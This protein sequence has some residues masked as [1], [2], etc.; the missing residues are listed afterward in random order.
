M[1]SRPVTLP[2][3]AGVRARRQAGGGV[4]EDAAIG[5][6]QSRV[7]PTKQGPS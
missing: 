5:D 1:V 7:G 3:G 2:E 6:R 4:Q